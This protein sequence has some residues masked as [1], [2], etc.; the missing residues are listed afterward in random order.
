VKNP[1][2]D[3]RLSDEIY[4]RGSGTSQAAANL[5]PAPPL[6]PTLN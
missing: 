4:V 6:F 1:K 5:L 3:C 2:R